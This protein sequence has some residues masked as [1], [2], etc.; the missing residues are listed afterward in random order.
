MHG[1]TRTFGRAIALGICA[2]AMLT[3]PARADVDPTPTSWTLRWDRRT[4]CASTLRHWSDLKVTANDT[5]PAGSKITDFGIPLNGEARLVATDGFNQLQYR[6][7]NANS[8][9]WR[10]YEI[11]FPNGATAHSFWRVTADRSC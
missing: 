7:R 3:G 6:D 11:Q 9:Y 5:I 2:S 4:I 10:F 1:T 8:D